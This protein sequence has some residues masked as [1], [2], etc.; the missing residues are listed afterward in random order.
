M[1]I[2]GAYAGHIL[3]SDRVKPH[4]E[5]AISALKAAGVRKTV[6]LTGDRR[7]AAEQVAEQLGIDEV[8]SELLPAGKVEKVEELMEAGTEKSKLAF[9]GR[10]HQR[11]HRCSDAPISASPWGLW[12]PTPP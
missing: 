8:Y 11:L 5:E 4:A 7:A 3:I 6:M 2:D 9:C 12:A 10:R 1:A